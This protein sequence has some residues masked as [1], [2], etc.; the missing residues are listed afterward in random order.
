MLSQSVQTLLILFI[1][2]KECFIQ[3]YDYLM[4]KNSS[5]KSSL[6]I[7]SLEFISSLKNLQFHLFKITLSLKE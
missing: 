3:F 6:L 1:T 5:K 7:D 2:I 4:R